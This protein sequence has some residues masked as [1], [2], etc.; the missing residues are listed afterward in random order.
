MSRDPYVYPGTT[1]LRNLA[2]LRDQ[3][4]LSWLED[5]VS[6]LALVELAARRLPGGYDLAH[7]QAFHR[8]VFG[9]VYPWAGEFR[10]VTTSKPGALF[11]LPGHLP[12]YAAEVLGGLAGAGYLRGRDRPRFLDGLAALWADLNA[13]HPFREGNGRATR[14]FL[15]QL[16][17]DAGHPLDWTGLDRSATLQASVAAHGGDNTAMRVL[18]DRHLVGPTRPG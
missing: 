10:T 1:V 15:R 11:C 18:L 8:F 17:A 6:A 5:R 7:L 13:L 9:D 12:G 14:A 4:A 16:A 3:L 2:G